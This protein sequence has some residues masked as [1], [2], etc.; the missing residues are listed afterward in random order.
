MNRRERNSEHY[1]KRRITRRQALKAGGIAALGLIY[2]KP[3][4]DTIRPTPVFA[5][6][7]SGGS[8]GGG[9]T[10]GE[11]TYTIYAQVSGG[12][13]DAYHAPFGWPGYSADRD[14]VYAGAP[15]GTTIWGGWRWTD[16]NIP[17]WATITAAYVELAQYGWSNVFT[18]TFAFEDSGNPSSF[19]PTSTPFNRWGNH[20]TFEIDWVWPKDLPG[21]WIQTPSLKDGV[22]ELV[23][24]YGG[25]DAIVLL[26]DGTGVTSREH[27]AW[28]SYDHAPD[29]GAKL[30]IEYIG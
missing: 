19:S 12:S 30:H 22:Q 4:I 27:H 15:G 23:D 2:A 29:K 14:R 28:S 8:T 10:S 24:N 6:Y 13:N 11:A 1:L 20:T 25:I 18:T 17:S 21:S 9:G 26:E 16:L 3:I 5:N 7:G